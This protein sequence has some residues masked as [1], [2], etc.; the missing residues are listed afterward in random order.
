MSLQWSAALA[1]GIDE[2]DDQ[3]RELFDRINKMLEIIARSAG[4]QEMGDV[5][6]FLEDYVVSHFAMEE[7]WMIRFNYPD[8]QKH[9]ERHEGFNRELALF[10]ER[11]AR[12]G[13]SAFLAIQI[14]NMLVEWWTNHIRT[15]DTA[16]GKFL[17]DK[18]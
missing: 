18:V 7:G 5:M 16:L 2:I 11:L 1:V 8:F 12:E 10:K 4:P 14:E 9:K 15:I 3:H 13:P 6:S 17:A